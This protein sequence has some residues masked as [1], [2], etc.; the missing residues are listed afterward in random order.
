MPAIEFLPCGDTGLAVQ[1]GH[2]IDRDLSRRVVT[3]GKAVSQAGIEGVLDA[4]PTYRSLLIHFD[5]LVTSH[6]ELV[7]K[8]DGY[9]DSS[10]DAGMAEGS[11]WHLPV[12]FDGE[13]MAG[14]LPAV[15]AWAGIGPEEVIGDL[16]ANPLYVYMI[17]FA[18]GQP[19]IG[20]LPERIAIPRRENPVPRVAA[21]SVVI[22]TG[23][24]VIYSIDN[25]TGWY[26]VGRTPVSLFDK[27]R[28]P[29]G[30]LSAGDSVTF[31]PVGREAFCSLEAR[32]SNGDRSFLY[33]GAP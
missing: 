15:A 20:D 21:G 10:D 19:Y 7:A 9:L 27:T 32:L 16:V 5:P 24:A 12:C 26:V 33:S 1:F 30:L 11:R 17:G 8:L 4:V 6:A 2:S 18:P 28:S 25:P 31:Y 22:A 23:K 14:D 13:D 3:L 29:P